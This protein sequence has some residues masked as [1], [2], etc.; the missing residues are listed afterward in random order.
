MVSGGLQ[1]VLASHVLRATL[2]LAAGINCVDAN[3]PYRLIRT[4][5]LPF[6]LK[7]IPAGFFLANVAVAV[8]LRRSRNW[9]HGVVSIGFR[10]RYGGG[11]A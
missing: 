10:E 11:P 3:V 8:L 1:R 4:E 6:V 9:K 2:L 5:G 7:K